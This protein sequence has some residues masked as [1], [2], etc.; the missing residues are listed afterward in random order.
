MTTADICP[1]ELLNS[2]CGCL[3]GYVHH[4][5]DLLPGPGCPEGDLEPD[6]CCTSFCICR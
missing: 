4:V 5:D 2:S 1:S 6:L 3:R